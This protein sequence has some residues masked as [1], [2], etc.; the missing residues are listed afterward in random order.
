MFTDDCNSAISE[1]FHQKYYDDMYDKTV[2]LS[3]K[4]EIKLTLRENIGGGTNAD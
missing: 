3:L 2:K 1:R 4:K